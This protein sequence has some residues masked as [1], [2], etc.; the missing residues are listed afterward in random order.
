MQCIKISL[1]GLVMASSMAMAK[2]NWRPLFNGK[3]FH[4]EWKFI[5]DS[6]FWTID[7]KDS[8]IVGFSS[9]TKTPYSLLFTNKIDYDQFTV[10][11]AYRLKAGCSGFWFRSHEKGTATTVDGPQVEVKREGMEQLEVGSIYTWP[12]PGWEA[13]HSRAYSVKIAPK[14]DEYQDV[15]LTVKKPLVYVNVNGFQALGETDA[16]ELASGAKPAW[17]YTTSIYAQLPGQFALQVHEGY[18][19]DVRFKNIM[20][21]EG[22]GDPKSKLYDG[23]TVSGFSKQPAVYQENGTCNTLGNR[24]E[25]GELKF[26]LGI[27]IQRLGNIVDL[28]IN[29]PRPHNV[30]VYALD[31]RILLC[32]SA[33]TKNTYA[34]AGPVQSGIYVVKLVVGN[35]ATWQK[36][37]I[38]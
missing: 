28:E 29:E 2:V 11:Y 1:A 16:N 7:A 24:M 19:I 32:G 3:S 12:T 10:K 14:V 22:C 26:R 27:K 18:P 6:T 20:I 34:L 5:G 23:E 35:Q 33:P 36:V 9:T 30:S 31:G 38:P 25:K 4:P 15:I 8:S 21:L 17:N 37:F 13:Q